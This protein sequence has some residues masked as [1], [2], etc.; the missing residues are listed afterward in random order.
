METLMILWSKKYGAVFS[1]AE[2]GRALHRWVA[3]LA[4]IGCFAM[5]SA[6]GADASEQAPPALAGLSAVPGDGCMTVSWTA[7]PGAATYNLKLSTTRGGQYKTIAT[8]VRATTVRLQKLANGTT[9]Y[10][11]VSAVN[12][13]GEGPDSQEVSTTP[14]AS[15][16]AASK[17]T[18]ADIGQVAKAGS[19]TELGAGRWSLAGTGRDIWDS[20][21]SFHYVYQAVSGE[22]AIICRV[23]SIQDT[24]EWAKSGLMFRSGPSDRAAHA[25]VFVTP[26]HGLVFQYRLANGAAMGKWDYKEGIVAT[27]D[28]PVWLKL[29]SEGAVIHAF[30]AQGRSRPSAW[31]SIGSV[32]GVKLGGDYLAGLAVCSR[33]DTMACNSA[34]GEVA[35]LKATGGIEK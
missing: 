21:D 20:V 16:G 7:A 30:F 29:V 11:V 33:S 26:R 13:G 22:Q 2:Q 24:N 31:S 10:C 28:N 18:Q 35:L 14:N 12:A 17:W 19:S 27:T 6:L 9:Y 1:G 4:L 5:M 15:G 34:F 3:F 23:D 32:D 8:N 25:G